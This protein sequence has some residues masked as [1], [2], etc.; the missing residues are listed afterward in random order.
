MSTGP[1]GFV[2]G[3]IPGFYFSF[4]GQSRFHS[5]RAADAEAMM[6][7]SGDVFRAP[8]MDCEGAAAPYV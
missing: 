8:Q 1:I 3:N 7:Q 4:F 2:C 5:S 6:F